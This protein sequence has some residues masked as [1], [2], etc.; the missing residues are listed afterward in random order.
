VNEDDLIPE[1]L[2]WRDRDRFRI[3]CEYCDS[4]MAVLSRQE[5]EMSLTR[6]KLCQRSSYRRRTFPAAPA[7]GAPAAPGPAC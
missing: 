5:G 6:D 4:T 7:R 1:V 3:W 2:A